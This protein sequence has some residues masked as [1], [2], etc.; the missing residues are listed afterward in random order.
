MRLFTLEHSRA[1]YRADFALYGLAVVALAAF[2]WR[3]GPRG[4]G[5]ESAAFTVLGLASWTALEYA[6]HRFVLHGLAPFRHWH[7]EHHRRPTA[8]IC[9]P[10]ILSGTL[11]AALVF[12]PAWLMAGLWR[13]SALT[14]G[15]LIGYLAYALTHHAMHHGR[16]GNTWLQQRKRWHALHHHADGRTGY[17]GVTG[18]FWDRAM[19]TAR[20]AEA[21]A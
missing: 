10:T 13:G 11:I 6:L 12:A 4:Q 19:G 15:V 1:A 2:L 7:A 17:Y 8:L 5:L 18:A 9:A 14:L 21:G 3:A 20:R 16:T